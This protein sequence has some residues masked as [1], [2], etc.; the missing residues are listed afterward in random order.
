MSMP[1]RIMTQDFRLLGQISKYES[2]QITSEWSGIGEVELHVNRYMPNAD[3]LLVGNIV[4]PHGR[5]DRAFII[6]HKEIALDEAGKITENWLIRAPSLKTWFS[7]KPTI[8]PAGKSHIEL[9]TDAESV[10]HALVE[11]SVINPIDSGMQIENLIAG[12]NQKRGD[13]VEWQS[14]YKVLS[15]ELEKISQLSGIGWNIIV[16]RENERFIFKT[17]EGLDLTEHNGDNPPA[18]FSPEFKTIQN[19]SYSESMLDYK[20]YAIVAGQGEGADRRIVE[21]GDPSITGTDRRVLFVDA[22][23]VEEEDENGNALPVEE[24]ERKLRER[25]EQKLAE[26]SQEVYLE[27]QAL[28]TVVRKRDTSVSGV[29]DDVALDRV[30][31]SGS[32]RNYAAFPNW[33]SWKGEGVSFKDHI[34]EYDTDLAS[35]AYQEARLMNLK[36]VTEYVLSFEFR[37][38]GDTIRTIGGHTDDTFL[39]GSKGYEVDGVRFDG[40]FSA[41]PLMSG[42]NDGKWHTVNYY[43]KTPETI[44][45]THRIY[46]QPNRGLGSIPLKAIV[47]HVRLTQGESPKEWQPAAEDV[48]AWYQ[49]DKT[50]HLEPINLASIGT[51]TDSLFTWDMSTPAG[52]EAHIEYSFDGRT[53]QLLG[54]TL[55]FTRNQSING[56]LFI[57][58]RLLTTNQTVTPSIRN[59]RYVINGYKVQGNPTLGRLTYGI[60]YNLGDMSTLQSKDWGVSLD[61]RITAVKEIYEPEKQAIELTFGNDRPTIFTKI[62]QEMEGMK[63]EITR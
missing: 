20:N 63:T 4:F 60:D 51:Y 53:W 35:G 11:A 15:E 55:P 13:R 16:D 41:P 57:R 10:M 31:L 25:G 26:H 45:G 43:F 44:T 56:R 19:L 38:L 18:V 32:G 6:E 61:A 24:V 9:N 58:I 29:A 23:D 49:A 54:N 59:F 2:L 28:G 34:I 30:D 40:R 37:D 39:L 48:S 17:F 5:L 46:I 33:Q 1:L 50:V 22:R 42:L 12:T 62:K 3:K 47:R 8:P 52:T 36:P 21:V 14:R 7:Q 27:G